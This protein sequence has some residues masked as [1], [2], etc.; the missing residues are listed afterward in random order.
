[1]TGAYLDAL[2]GSRMCIKERYVQ[3]TTGFLER[4]EALKH[5]IYAN[6]STAEQNLKRRTA[7]WRCCRV[8]ACPG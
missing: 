3:A 1:M 4:A 2:I 7:R 6:V 8:K 5:P